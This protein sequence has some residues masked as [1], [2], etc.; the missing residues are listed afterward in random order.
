MVTG[1]IVEDD[2]VPQAR[3]LLHR[4]LPNRR[5]RSAESAWVPVRRLA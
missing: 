3:R 5:G 4:W 1:M 2:P